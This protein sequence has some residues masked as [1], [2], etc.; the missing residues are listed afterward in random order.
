MQELYEGKDFSVAY[1]LEAPET[2]RADNQRKLTLKTERAVA[3]GLYDFL[4]R[5]PFVF[6]RPVANHVRRYTS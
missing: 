1:C 3:T 5:P 4:P 6:S 2:S